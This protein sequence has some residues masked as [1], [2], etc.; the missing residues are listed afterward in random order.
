MYEEITLGGSRCR[1]D[2]AHRS[3]F[4]KIEYDRAVK[5]PTFLIWNKQTMVEWGNQIPWITNYHESS[6]L[7]KTKH[8]CL[9]YACVVII[10]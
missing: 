6:Y 5:R 7:L 2:V 8:E 9:I 4:T 1:D 10:R 3:R